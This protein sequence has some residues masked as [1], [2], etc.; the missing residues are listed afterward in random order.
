MKKL[1]KRFTNWIDMELEIA[2][3]V[4]SVAAMNMTKQEIDSHVEIIKKRWALKA[5]N[6]E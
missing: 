2:F 5:N 6:N 1:W 3:F 4:D